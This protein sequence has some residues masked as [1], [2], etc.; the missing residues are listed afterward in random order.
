MLGFANCRALFLICLKNVIL[1]SCDGHTH[2]I[3]HDLQLSCPVINRAP[4]FT[5]E[6]RSESGD[7]SLIRQKTKANLANLELMEGANLW[8][9]VR[10]R[11]SIGLQASIC[12]RKK[13]VHISVENCRILR[14]M[15]YHV[16]YGMV[17]KTIRKLFITY[18]PGF[19]KRS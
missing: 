2:V 11:G 4:H 15:P 1:M 17:L 12:V 9:W 14:I 3:W 18:K 7:F 10:S 19:K 8:S 5:Y 13:I 6:R 16:S